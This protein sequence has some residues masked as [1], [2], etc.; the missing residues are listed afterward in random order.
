VT[1]PPQGFAQQ[2]APSHA[3][4]SGVPDFRLRTEDNGHDLDTL[5]WVRALSGTGAERGAAVERLHA[6]L[7]RAARFEVARARRTG[8]HGGSAEFDDLARPAADDALVAVLSQL[9][10]YR[11]QSRF[12]TWASKFA[13][14]EAAQ[15][16]RKRSWHG[17]EIP[18]ETVGLTRLLSVRQRPSAGQAEAAE[19]LHTVHEAI[20]ESMTPDERAVLVPLV[21]NDVPIDIL[22]ER[23]GMPRDVLYKTLRKARGKLRVALAEDGA[24]AGTSRPI[25][26]DETGPPGGDSGSGPAPEF[27]APHPPRPAE[28]HAGGKESSSLPTRRSP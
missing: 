26:Y 25:V 6:L 27:R 21:L 11:G 20:V 22:A 1:T 13:L 7:L 19:F 10:T 2:A 16:A 5:D 12:T 23:R 15:K 3:P 9:D 4:E 24:A 8:P 17:R 14:F 18:R 28:T